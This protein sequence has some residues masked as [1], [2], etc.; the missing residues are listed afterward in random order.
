VRDGVRLSYGTLTR[1]PVRPPESVDAVA[2]GF[3]MAW[4]WLLIVPVTI[5]IGATGWVLSLAGIPS[6]AVGLVVVGLLQFST[7]FMHADGLADTADGLGAARGRAGA[8]EIMRK[9]DIG[10]FGV[11]TLIIVL[12]LQAATAGAI[13][14][15]PRGWLIVGGALAV[16][17]VA[18]A[19]GTAA[20][21]P[22][23]REDGLGAA[24]AG[25]VGIPALVVTLVLSGAVM[26]AVG[27]AS[28]IG[29]MAGAL[30]WAASLAVASW[31]LAHVVRR[32]GG[33]TGD[34]LGALVE[35]AAAVS[36]LVLSAFVS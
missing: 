2:A 10:P 36:L 11:V 8:L 7:R 24:V 22:S 23:A 5:L 12:G 20:G 35:T 16:S 17:R 29:F 34:V 31:L 28:G 19:L 18:L 25:A 3:A 6:L 30:S 1:F 14:A 15:A 21:V 9:S 33:I 27:W 32:L 26:S 4:G 13:S